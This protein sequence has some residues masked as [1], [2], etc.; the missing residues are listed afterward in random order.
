MDVDVAFGPGN[1][2]V[3]EFSG[4]VRS[5]SHTFANRVHVGNLMS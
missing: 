4:L 5:S 1:D 2:D 3:N